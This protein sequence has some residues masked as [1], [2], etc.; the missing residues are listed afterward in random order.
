MLL[1]A[2]AIGLVVGTA[3]FFGV[4]FALSA[5]NANAITL[6]TSEAENYSVLAPGEPTQGEGRAGALLTTITH[7]TDDERF[8]S[9]S[10]TE[11]ADVPPSQRGLVLHELLIGALK[12]AP[13]VSESDLEST[14]VMEAFLT[15][16]EQFTIAGDPA[17]RFPLTVGEAA[18]SFHIV[19]A[20]HES[21]FYLLV[22]S[23]SDSDD[24]RDE[25]FLDS[26]TY[27]D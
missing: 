24:D 15:E 27:L 18:G 21:G 7:W 10:S 20:A 8:Y 13:G 11:S 17:L 6:Y 4:Q 5:L 22:F 1:I 16:P 23:D 14:A 12:E 26:F 9:V 3:A 2:I 19:F 25:N